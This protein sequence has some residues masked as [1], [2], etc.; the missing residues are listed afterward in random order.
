[1]TVEGE[2]LEGRRGRHARVAVLT[3]IE[4]EFDAVQEE[5]GAFHSVRGT[6]AFAPAAPP[7]GNPE[8]YPFVLMQC[9]DRSNGPAQGSTRRLSDYFMP[10]V[11]LLVGIAG[12][13]QRL[14]DQ[15]GILA[16]KG[17]ALPGDVVV[18]DYVH[19]A[20]FTKNEGGQ[21]KLRFFAIDSPSAVL[22]ERH[23]NAVKSTQHT[24]SPWYDGLPDRPAPRDRPAP[25]KG[26]DQR[27]PREPTQNKLP[28]LIK[29]EVI[30]VEGL[31]GDPRN[32]HQMT[33][34][35][36]FDHAV[37]VDME[38]MGVGRAL[39][40]L[41]DEVHYDPLW[42]CIRGI[43]DTVRAVRPPGHAD[44]MMPE[45]AENAAERDRWKRYSATAAAKVAHRLLG[46]L[47]SEGRNPRAEDQGAPSYDV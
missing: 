37:A 26:L 5:L 40:D 39:H 4:D 3:V 44:V 10:E 20:D 34:V 22:I 18:G 47:L 11:V 8:R 43:S 29:G 9:A 14:D 6:G 42:M 31:A 38:S 12:G 28:R 33:L 17:D 13:V 30:A 1:V 19:Y 32:Q 24:A 27:V 23:F 7:A 35:N 41:R 2:V 16:W 45:V 21:E 15:D 36:R 25:P 46:L